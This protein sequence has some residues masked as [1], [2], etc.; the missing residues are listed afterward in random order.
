MGMLLAVT[1]LLA[2]TPYTAVA[3][4]IV[5]DTDGIAY[6]QDAE[7]FVYQIPKGATTKKAV[8]FICIRGRKLPLHF[9]KM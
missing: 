5:K 8:L 1:V 7:G 2:G 9:R 6:A 4:D 3:A